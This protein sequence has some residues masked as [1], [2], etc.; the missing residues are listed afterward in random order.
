MVAVDWFKDLFAEPSP[1]YSHLGVN[2]RLLRYFEEPEDIEIRYCE[3]VDEWRFIDRCTAIVCMTNTDYCYVAELYGLFPN[4]KIMR[5]IEGEKAKMVRSRVK[6]ISN[7]SGA[8]ALNT[9]NELLHLFGI[10]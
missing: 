10:P 8:E 4:I 9:F 1:R 7:L 2:K 3:L 5:E 6:E